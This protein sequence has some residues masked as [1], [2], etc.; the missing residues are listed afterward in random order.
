MNKLVA[1]ALAGAFFL[2]SGAAQAG[3]PRNQDDKPWGR[4]V[5]SVGGGL[6]GQFF[7]DGG[8]SLS[9]GVSGEYFVWH[10][11]GLG[12]G[13]TNQFIFLSNS[14]R[15]QYPNIE[16][17]VPTYFG[18]LSPTLRVFLFRSYRFSPYILGGVGPVF[19]NNQAPTLGQWQA[20]GG[21]LIGLGRF[22]ALDIGVGVSQLFTTSACERGTS[23]VFTAAETGMA[24]DTRVSVGQCS[25]GIFPRIGV[26]FGFGGKKSQD[27]RKSRRERK[28]EKEMEGWVPPEAEPEQGEPPPEFAPA[29]EPVE[30]T[31]VE[32]TPGY[33]APAA[34][35]APAPTPAPEPEPEPEPAAEPDATGAPPD[36][37]APPAPVEGDPGP[38]A[39]AP[40]PPANAPET[41]D[42]PASPDVEPDLPPVQQPSA[43]GDATPPGR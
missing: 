38:P 13:Y 23:D 35:P 1:G 15:D 10:G 33:A 36:G 16:D 20:G 40:Q 8:G 37:A 3:P 31:P 39:D 30:P 19:T 22:A 28:R 9:F 42:G 27:D 24:A 6:G 5:F 7:G 18:Y 12:L 25:I 41:P 26:V 34:D 14:F 29:P 4:G 43:D 2:A 11:I 32:E 17:R 21:V